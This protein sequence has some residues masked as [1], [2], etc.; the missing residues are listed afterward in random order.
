MSQQTRRLYEFGAFRLDA[1]E[2]LLLR[3]GE[4]VPLTPKAFEMLL[5]LVENSGRLLGKQELMQRLWP[6]SF[7]EE[8]SLAQN[9]SLLRKVLGESQEGE[10]FIETVPRRGYRFIAKVRGARGDAD[11]IALEQSTANITV[12]EKKEPE[13][14]ESYAE[15]PQA[16][17]RK[18]VESSEANRILKQMRK[19]VLFTATL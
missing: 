2:R 14:S 17:T 9:V 7:V 11:L 6:D 4:I 5:A 16:G 18:A 12:K 1:Q 13:I 8:G 10:K 19:P 3:H 15:S